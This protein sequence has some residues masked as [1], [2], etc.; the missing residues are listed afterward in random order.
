MKTRVSPPCRK[1]FSLALALA[2]LLTLF[3]ILPAQAAGESFSDPLTAGLDTGIYGSTATASQELYYRFTASVTGSYYFE[4]LATPINRISRMVICND[5]TVQI[6]SGYSIAAVF[7]DAEEEYYVKLETSNTPGAFAFKITSPYNVEGN[8]ADF[9]IAIPEGLNKNITGISTV[10]EQDIFYK[11]TASV[12]GS[13]HFATLGISPNAVWE[14]IICSDD[15]VKIG[16][17]YSSATVSLVAGKVYYVRIRTSSTPGQFG[18]RIT[19]PYNV[20]G[21]G[22][23]FNMAIPAALN[24][25]IKGITTVTGQVLHYKFTAP[26]SGIYAF[27]KSSMSP[28]AVWEM[29]ICN[30]AT[31]KIGSGYSSATATLSAGKVYYVKLETSSTPGQFGFR[32]TVPGTPGTNALAPKIT[33]QP[34]GK[35]TVNVGSYVWI[36]VAATRSDNSGSLS[37]QWYSNTKNRNSGGKSISGATGSSY[38]VPSKKAGTMYYYCV[39]TVTDTSKTGTK[40]ARTVSKTAAIKLNAVPTKVKLSKKKLTLR[41]RGKNKKATLKATVS[42]KNAANKKVRWHSSNP[43]VATVSKKGVVT[44]KRKGTANIWATTRQGSK[45]ARCKVT[46]K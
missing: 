13:Y 16:S 5:A 1:I 30:D 46:V 34:K 22:A 36:S 31:V 28:N 19:S 43:W 35:T 26:V 24:A 11:F 32:I 10:P 12:T 42:P 39:V 33:T 38:T 40:T 15:T 9:D 44:A 14:M 25:E 20:D 27:N 18:F 17:G 7:L 23:N 21:N 8:G 6:G 45:M 4:K 2:M 3:P 37:Y 41:T 29:V